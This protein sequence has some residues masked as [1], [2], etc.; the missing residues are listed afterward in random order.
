MH[1]LMVAA[2][3][4]PFAGGVETHTLEVSRR[5]VEMGV[6]VTVL[7]TDPSGQLPAVES[8]EGV[9]IRRVRAWPADGDLYL[10]PELSRW[11]RRRPD[12]IIHC[13][14]F[15]TLVAPLAMLAALTR[16]IPLVVTFHSGG[17]SSGWRDAIR[18]IQTALLSPLLR[19]ADRLI[20]VSNF[21]AALFTRRLRT[22][23]G[24]IAVVPNGAELPSDDGPAGDVERED[25]IVSVGRLER[26]K[27]HHRVIAA[28]PYVAREIPAIRLEIVGSGP[29][30]DSLREA[31][32]AA[33]VEDR[34][35]IRSIPSERRSELRLL[36][37]RAR[38][39]TLLSAYESQGISVIEALAMGAPV[40]TADGSALGEMG[41]RGMVTTV[42]LTGSDHDIAT[43]MLRA[44]E[45]PAAPISADLP[46]W[47]DAAAALFDIYR[48][49][50]DTRHG[51]RSRLMGP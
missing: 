6:D 33:G 11:I 42:S 37:R 9:P 38:L 10:A 7:T 48:D 46:T 18:P 26:Y 8:I 29:Y 45:S 1:V 20:A 40:L 14:G 24:R 43:A 39:V 2:R 13:Q 34:V 35:E 5:L 17:H 19:R 31:A 49:V 50:L 3:F 27:G 51:V 16:G 36:L 28:L 44:L 15:H 22:A 32:R 12:A 30:E 41:A 25:V 21:E 4:P 47:D 23:P